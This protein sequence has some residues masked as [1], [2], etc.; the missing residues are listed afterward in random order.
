MAPTTEIPVEIAGYNVLA[1]SLP[2]MPSYPDAAKHFLYIGP[3]QPRIPVPTASRSLFLVNIPFDATEGHIKHLLSA[4]I[5]LPAGRIEDV[6]FECHK[7][8]T[9]KANGDNT[10]KDK[11]DGKSKKRKRGNTGE[12]GYDFGSAALPST[13]DRELKI[14]KLTGVV[15]FVDRASTDAA[16]AAIKATRKKRIEPLWGEGLE[17]KTPALGSRSLSSYSMTTARA[18]LFQDT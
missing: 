10:P 18:D 13:W 16:L 12:Q 2:P 15:V 3:H 14:E 7:K 8:T 5:R 11:P 4:Q 9:S 17:G 1:L 6:Q